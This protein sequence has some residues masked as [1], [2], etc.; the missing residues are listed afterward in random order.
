MDHNEQVLEHNI[1]PHLAYSTGL[2]SPVFQNNS[3][4]LFSPQAYCVLFLPLLA[5]ST[6][7]AVKVVYQEDE[8]E[9]SASAGRSQ[10][11]NALELAA[12]TAVSHPNIVQV[13]TG[14]GYL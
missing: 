2:A 10:L 6:E 4:C 14:L 8:E 3:L 9:G 5:C 1:A 13:G 7:V 12:V 11:R